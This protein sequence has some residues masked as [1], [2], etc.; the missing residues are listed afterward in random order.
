N[1]FNRVSSCISAKDM[2]DRLEITYESIN[3]VKEAKISILVRDYEMSTMHEN[4]DV[5]TNALQALDKVYTNS[6]I[7][8]KILWC[9]PRVWMPNV[10]IIEEDKDLN[11]LPLE[12]L[13]RSLMTVGSL[14]GG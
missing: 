11:T 6:E 12:D 9:L 7:V 13:L 1:D 3:Q 2:W 10:T 5:I 4:V 8:R 14:E